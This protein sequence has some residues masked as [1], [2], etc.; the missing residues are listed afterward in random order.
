MTQTVTF[1]DFMSSF[2]EQY[3][4]YFSDEG[5]RALFDYLEQ[6]EADCDTTIE[7]DTVALCTE[8]TEY[9]SFEELQGVYWDIKTMEELEDKT[10][11]IK[12]KETERFIIADY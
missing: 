3:D 2:S 12:I 4:T 5:K 11:V 1:T 9:D 7:L 6:Y 8:Y 10:T